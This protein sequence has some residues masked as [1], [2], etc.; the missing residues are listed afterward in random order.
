M[1]GIGAWVGVIGLGVTVLIQTVAVAFWL[2]RLSQRMDSVEAKT[3][4]GAAFMEKVVKLEVQMGHVERAT[5]KA[6]TQ[7]EGVNRQLAN[8]ATRNFGKIFDV[9]QGA[10]G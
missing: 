5:D 7:L 4:N 1:T 6:A 8:I 2:G 10:D 9:S 3:D